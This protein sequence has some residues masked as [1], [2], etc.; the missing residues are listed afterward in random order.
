MFAIK[1]K[2]NVLLLHFFIKWRRKKTIFWGYYKDFSNLHPSVENYDFN[3]LLQG[4][5]THYP[6]LQCRQD[7]VLIG[8][9]NSSKDRRL[10]GSIKATQL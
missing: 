9:A 1:E 2:K 6:L 4:V 8:D 7:K 10:Y 5:G 3:I